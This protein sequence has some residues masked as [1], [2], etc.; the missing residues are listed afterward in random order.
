MADK[1]IVAPA[2][3]RQSTHFT[4]RSR[5]RLPHWELENGTYFVTVR[6][7]GT[8]PGRVVARLKEEKEQA[9]ELEARGLLINIIDDYLDTGKG[10]CPLKVSKVATVV[11]DTLRHFDGDRYHLH[12]W[13]IMPN[14]L[15]VVFTAMSHGEQPERC[16]QGAGATENGGCRQGAG[17]TKHQLAAIMHSWKS[18]T[19]KEVNKILGRSG[20]FWQREYYDHLIR[21]E[22][23]Y[24]ACIEYTLNNPVSAGLC[25]TWEEWPW[26]G[27][28]DLE[29]R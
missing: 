7:A 27:I 4:I 18:Y 2:T 29:I 3:C 28:G 24:F 9:S 11:V 6:V 17:A 21:N 13:C 20:R 25:V 8:L 19:S 15:H 16:R 23:E 26:A 14:H 10:D 12:A 1:G 5:G 22:E